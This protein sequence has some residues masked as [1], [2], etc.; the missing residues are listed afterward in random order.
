MFLLI[1]IYIGVAKC[2]TI[3]QKRNRGPT[4]FV[5]RFCTM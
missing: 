2:C 1:L 5:W 4:G 3:C